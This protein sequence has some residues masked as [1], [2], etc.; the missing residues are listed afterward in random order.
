G[1]KAPASIC[2]ALA[3]IATKREDYDVVVM[4]RGGGSFEELMAF[5]DE[6]VVRA[7]YACPVPT[8]VAIGHER[9]VTL[10]EEVADVR[11]STPTDCARRLVPDRRDLSYEVS[12]MGD[13]IDTA[14]DRQLETLRNATTSIFASTDR[15]LA[16]SR[17]TLQ[18]RQY[19]VDQATDRWLATL[20]QRVGAWAALTAA[21]DP[22]R[23][24][25]RGYILVKDRATG[26]FISR[27]HALRSQQS[28][29]LCLQDGTIPAT[30]GEHTTQQLSIF[31]Y[32]QEKA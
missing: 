22:K 20:Q 11:G 32:G 17:Q 29:E 14:I 3:Y 26:A 13:R 28:V 16:R 9:D 21:V 18:T 8:L 10:A 25:A 6:R 15:W 5:Q 19:A 24:L 2:R 7:I 12:V 23:V 1:E 30:I 27:A 31:S 4:T